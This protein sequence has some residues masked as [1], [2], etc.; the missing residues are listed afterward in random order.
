MFWLNPANSGKNLNSPARFFH[1]MPTLEAFLEK[2]K[3]YSAWWRVDTTIPE[4][5][6]KAEVFGEFSLTYHLVFNTKQTY[7]RVLEQI[8]N[9]SLSFLQK[10]GLVGIVDK[11]GKFYVSATSHGLDFV[12]RVFETLQQL[13]EAADGYLTTQA[14]SAESKNL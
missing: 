6:D 7:P 13:K 11:D 10:I 9:D 1:A 3:D 14:S 4:Q 8:A 5:L 12:M 2:L